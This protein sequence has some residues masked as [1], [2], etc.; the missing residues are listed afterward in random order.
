MLKVSADDIMRTPWMWR[1]EPFCIADNMYFVGDRDVCS[2]LFDT[3]EGLLLL[4]T[5]YPFASYLLFESIREMG[6]DPKDVDGFRVIYAENAALEPAEV[7]D[8]LEVT[9]D[10]AGLSFERTAQ[11]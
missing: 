7:P 9:F 8:D 1:V 2:H 11:R 5:G 4:D 6:F 10:E 3:G